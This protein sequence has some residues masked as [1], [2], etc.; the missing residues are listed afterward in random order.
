MPSTVLLRILIVLLLIVG[1]GRR[2]MSKFDRDFAIKECREEISI[3]ENDPTMSAELK[4]DM[5]E[6][7][8]MQ[9][10]ELT[11]EKTEKKSSN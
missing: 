4:R 2:G 8:Q 9:L 10:N 5:I 11:I 1:C 6:R 7:I 3:I